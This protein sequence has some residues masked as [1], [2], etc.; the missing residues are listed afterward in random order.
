MRQVTDSQATAETFLG[1]LGAGNW[2]GP[3]NSGAPAGGD[4][5]GLLSRYLS[6]SRSIEVH[7]ASQLNAA[8]TTLSALSVS[9]N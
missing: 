1:V 5:N 7:G 9:V 4:E 3:S 2:G 6:E 8:T